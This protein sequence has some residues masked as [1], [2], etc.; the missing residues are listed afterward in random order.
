MSPSPVG[1]RLTICVWV[2]DR[3]ERFAT[4][5]YVT[6]PVLPSLETVYGHLED[7]WTSRVLSNQGPKHEWLEQELRSV[8]RVRHLTLFANGT[9]ALTLGL[10][11]FGLR[12]EVITT[13]FTF[14]A[15]PHAI[16]WN[17]AVPVFCDVHPETLCIDPAAVEAM[18]T[19]RTEA[20]LGVHVYGFPCDVDALQR[21]AERHGLRVIYDAAHAFLTEVDARPIGDFGDLSMFSFH[22]TKLFH[23]AEGGCLVYRDPSLSPKLDLLKNFGI[24]DENSVL[25]AGLNAKLNEVQCAIGLAMINEIEPERA[26]RAAIKRRYLELLSTIDGVHYRRLP[27][28]VKDSFQYMPIRINAE[29]FGLTRDE[30]YRELLSFNIY[31][32]KYFFPL[33]T[34]YA[35]YANARTGEIP[36]ARAAASEVLCLPFYG[37]MGLEAVDRICDILRYVRAKAPRKRF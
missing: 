18:I 19:P 8:M 24:Q 9:L 5:L 14:P 29:E 17:G 30:V 16:A 27:D 26:R 31:S 10:R 7:L 22:A 36:N 23:T 6:R 12:G 28:D 3:P 20:I 32:R 35:P 33:C 34:D 4:P 25:M 1:A 2:M 11:A 21:I 13:P 15:T 37:D